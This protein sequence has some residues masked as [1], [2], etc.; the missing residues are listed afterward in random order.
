[1]IKRR[2][3]VLDRFGRE[4]EDE[5]EDGRV[6]CPDGGMVSVGMMFM[7]ARNGSYVD[8]ARDAYERYCDQLSSAHKRKDAASKL[9]D[10][11]QPSVWGWYVDWQRAHG[12]M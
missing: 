6:I 8:K 3:R 2:T 1:M 5:D 9:R 10:A 11:K 7:D 12:H 4:V